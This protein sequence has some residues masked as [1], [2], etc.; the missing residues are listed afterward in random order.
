MRVPDD[1]VSG[2]VRL[3]E[4]PIPILNPNP[5]PN[6]RVPDDTVQTSCLQV[7]AHLL[8]QL[9]APLLCSTVPSGY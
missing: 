9:E 4:L 5:N 8:E 2:R 1:T 7:C 6:A 3:R